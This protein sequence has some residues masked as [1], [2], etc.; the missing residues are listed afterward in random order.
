[1][2]LL[3]LDT[4]KEKECVRIGLSVLVLTVSALL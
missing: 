2:M 4:R 3:L 1:M